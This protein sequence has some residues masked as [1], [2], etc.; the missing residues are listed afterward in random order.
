MSAPF[1]EPALAIA[2][3]IVL[4]KSAPNASFLVRLEGIQKALLGDTT[5]AT[6]SG[7]L[8]NHVDRRTGGSDRKEGIRVRIAAGSEFS[9]IGDG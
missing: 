9:P 1:G 6:D 4:W 7:C 5:R 2:S 8:M 3:A